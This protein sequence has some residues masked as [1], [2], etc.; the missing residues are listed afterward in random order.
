LNQAKFGLS[1]GGVSVEGDEEGGDA[2]RGAAIADAG[3]PPPGLRR[4]ERRPVASRASAIR[5]PSRL[6]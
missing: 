1:Y 3:R 2:A 4:A 5:A 6:A